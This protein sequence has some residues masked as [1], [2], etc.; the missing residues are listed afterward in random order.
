MQPDKIYLNNHVDFTISY[1]ESAEFEGSRI[2]GIEARPRSI[3]HNSE[4]S[5]DCSINSPPLEFVT[6]KDNPLKVVYSYSVVFK[7]SEIKWASRWD[8]YLKTSQSSVH[9]FSIV[10]SLI[11]VLFLSGMIGVILVRTLHRDISRYNN[12]DENDETQEEF[13]WKL[14]HG[15]V[16]R[17]PAHPMVFSIIVGNGSQVLAMVIVTLIFACLGFLS[18]ATR[19]GLMT[20]LVVLYILFSAL[21]GYVSA[22]IYKMFGGERW[23]NNVLVTASLFTVT[24]FGIFFILNLVLWAL[25]S[26]AAV[27]F[28]TMVALVVLWFGLSVPLT[29]IGAYYGFKEDAIEHPVRTN[30]IPRQVPIQRWFNRSPFTLL[31]GGMLPFGCVFVQLYFIFSSLWGEKLYYVFGFLSL[32]FVIWAIT[33]IESTILLVYFSLCAEDYHWW[34]KSIHS[35]GAAA[36]YLFLYAVVFYFRQME[37]DGLVNLFVYAGYTLILLTIYWVASATIGFLGTFVFVRTIYAA[38]KVD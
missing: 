13:G 3:K 33:T 32:V 6:S 5:L 12:T 29:F 38:V 35:A 28:G 27:P 4:Y 36:F 26:S 19:G 10:N 16:F 1:H 24:V 22:R 25:G 14:I 15:D 9:W 7:F 37:V 18:P 8:A 11:V 34:W 20:S 31:I 23:R 17:P 30:K 2:V 21:A